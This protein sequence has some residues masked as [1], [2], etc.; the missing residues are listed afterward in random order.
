MKRPPWHLLVVGAVLNCLGFVLSTLWTAEQDYAIQSIGIVVWL[1]ILLVLGGHV[2]TAMDRLRSRRSIRCE[3]R[4]AGCHIR[5][6]A[7]HR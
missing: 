1:N 7:I 6:E 5:A 2:W 4:S 3:R